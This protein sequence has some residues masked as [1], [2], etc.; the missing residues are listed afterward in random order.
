V[1]GAV[2]TPVDDASVPTVL[3][4]F[5]PAG[6]DAGAGLDAGVRSSTSD[7]AQDAGRPSDKPRTTPRALTQQVIE[8]TLNASRAAFEACGRRRG[9]Q[10]P[11][12]GAITLTL[13]VLRGGEVS[14]VS[15]QAAEA[16]LCQ[17]M[18]A[19]AKRVRFPAHTSP[20][21]TFSIP[22]LLTREPPR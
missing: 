18:A 3:A 16:Q 12:S 20:S 7:G 2:A 6:D 21:V 1:V 9:T 10:L 13:T 11:K 19:V 15:C 17:C 14:A 8:R 5:V 22:V 4:P